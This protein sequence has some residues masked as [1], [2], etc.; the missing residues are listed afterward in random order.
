MDNKKIEN[1]MKIRSRCKACYPCCI[2]VV[3]C[4]RDDNSHG[5]GTDTKGSFHLN[6]EAY[7]F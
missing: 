1:N 4:D 3:G 7:E 5:H 6:A 2:G